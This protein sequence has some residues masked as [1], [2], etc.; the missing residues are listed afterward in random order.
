M[1]RGKK[2][3]EEEKNDKIKV[4]ERLEKTV[5]ENDS[6]EMLYYQLHQKRNMIQVGTK[7]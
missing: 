3:E 5:R 4:R 6:F 2:K 1:R 7:D